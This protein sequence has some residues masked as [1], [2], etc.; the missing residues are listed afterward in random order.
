[1]L[2]VWNT[3]Q[4]SNPYNGHSKNPIETDDHLPWIQHTISADY[5]ICQKNISLIF[6]YANNYSNF[7][8]ITSYSDYILLYF[9]RYIVGLIS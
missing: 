6:K 1:M 9:V 3:S 5:G 7:N 8:Y 2:G 4:N